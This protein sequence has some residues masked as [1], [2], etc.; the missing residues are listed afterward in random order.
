MLNITKLPATKL[1]KGHFSAPKAPLAHALWLSMLPSDR[2]HVVVCDDQAEVARLHT[3]LAFFGVHAHLFVDWET[4]PY[5]RLSVHDDIVSERLE[6]L[7][8][9]PST[10]ILL[11]SVASLMQRVAPPAWLLSAHFDIAIGQHFNLEQERE[12][13]VRAGYRAVDSVY[14]AGEFAVRG[15]IMD[16]FVMGQALPLRLELFDDEVESIRFFDSD[17]QRSLSDGELAKRRGEP[18]GTLAYPDKVN[19]T[20]FRVLPAKEFPLHDKETFR[21]NFARLF[22]DVSHRKFDLYQEVMNGITPNGIE[23]YQ[24]LFFSET[25]WQN[26]TLFHYLPSNSCFIV[27]DHL[28]TTQDNAWQA[29]CQRYDNY[30]FDKQNP[31][32]PPA[33]L[34]LPQ[35]ELFSHLNHFTQYVL[36]HK[37]NSYP[38]LLNAPIIALPDVAINHHGDEPLAALLTFIATT[39]EPI[40]LIAESAG[41]REVLVELLQGHLDYRL[42]AS[43]ADFMAQKDSLG[44]QIGISVAP[45]DNTLFLEGVCCLLT[46]AVLFG[47][48]A[49]NHRHHRRKQF[50]EEVLLKSVAELSVG[51]LVVH[52]EHGIGRYCGL[53]LLDVGDG[54]QEFIHLRYADDAD[55]YVPMTSL[56]LIG[57]YSGNDSELVALSKIGSGKW[58]KARQKTLTQIYDVAAELLNIQ[59]RRRAKAGIAFAIDK[60]QYELFASGFAFDE[61]D[62][63]QLAISAVLADMTAN[64]PMDRLICGDVGFG[65]TEVAMRAAFVAVMAG[66]QVAVLVPTTLLAKQHEDNFRS[67]FADWAVRIEGLS[68][69][70]AKKAADQLLQDL[71]DGKIDIIIGTHKLLQEDV[72][73]AKLGLMIVDEEHRFGVRHKERIKALQANIDSLTMTATPIPRTL[74]MALSGMQDISI[75]ATAPAR[76]LPIK[77]FVVEKNTQTTT[78]AI[79]RE[80]LRG[81]Q[82]YYLHNEVA[83]IS[84]AAAALAELLPEARIGIAHGQMKE[85][86][87]TSVM[88]DFYHKKF[89][90]LVA[91]TIIETGIDIPNANTMIINRADKFG[92]AQLHQLRGRVG[93]SHHQ[94]YC[95][96][97]VPSIKGL[98]SDA[99]KRLDA[100]ARANTLGAGFM[101]ASEDLEIRGAGELLGKEQSGNMQ[102][103][104]FGLYMDM[105]TRAT[106]AI[107]AG[108]EPKLDSPLEL[109]SDI[110]LHTSALIPADY[111]SDVHERLLF[112]KRIAG[113]DTWS[114]LTKLRS[115]MIDRFGAMPTAL[116]QL[117]LVHQLRVVAHPLGISKVD[118]THKTLTLEF[119]P[120]TPIDALTIVQLLQSNNNYAM[121]GATGLRYTFTEEKDSPKERYESALALLQYFAQTI[122]ANG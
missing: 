69:F 26:S 88:N 8:N 81:G 42:F 91:S 12:R 16:I 89:N 64:K 85:Q 39:D 75:I 70:G 94:A 78:D 113:S 92:L 5:E 50:S 105:L 33:L 60:V 20:A 118:V 117:F 76:R 116:A 93:R 90:V 83:S 6:L 110:N 28:A 56:A 77:T 45:I 107:K 11:V 49:S 34:Y 112:Y 51:N 13:L 44:Q 103:I 31:I 119:R 98:S 40:L 62:D 17:S 73:F 19:V 72:K 23:Y 79:L 53:V 37:D 30:R 84:T 74:N 36:H 82:V 67:R 80:I 48:Q 120:D 15:G 14:S 115:E 106:K 29:I 122:E 114:M 57:R 55:I 2:L 35:N 1:A 71:K 109:L 25:H 22:P 47:R 97:F 27:N 54:A 96:L 4:L 59:A 65:K 58:D 24:P 7:S 87:L 95:Y 52:M 66:Y 32:L 86:E 61:T 111:L 38:P 46:E 108:R 100:V 21:Q 18:I 9:M 63:Q 43:F 41:R 102:T 101:L 104:G 3:E 68:R 99:K 121:L 10:G